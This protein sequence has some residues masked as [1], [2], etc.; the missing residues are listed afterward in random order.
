MMSSLNQAAQS[1][2]NIEDL[3]KTYSRQKPRVSRVEQLQD[4]AAITFRPGGFADSFSGGLIQ[5]AGHSVMFTLNYEID[6]A[7]G[8]A[9][10]PVRGLSGRVLRNGCV[11]RSPQEVCLSMNFA[12]QPRQ[13]GRGPVI[14]PYRNPSLLETALRMD[15]RCQFIV[16]KGRSL[17]SAVQLPRVLLGFSSNCLP[18]FEVTE[19]LKQRAAANAGIAIND[20]GRMGEVL[21]DRL[22]RDTWEASFMPVD[23]PLN[24]T[25]LTLLDRELCPSQSQFLGAYEDFADLVGVGTSNP[26]RNLD[27]CP[28]PNPARQIWSELGFGSTPDL[29][30]QLPAETLGKLTSLMRST[31]GDRAGE[32]SDEDLC[33][34]LT[35][36]DTPLLAWSKLLPAIRSRL[37]RWADAGATDDDLRLAVIEPSQ[38]L[39]VRYA[40][41]VQVVAR[42]AISSF[43]DPR[44]RRTNEQ[45]RVSS[46]TNNCEPLLSTAT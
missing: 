40:S 32:F 30:Q 45:A 3:M 7:H 15:H 44:W 36:L 46:V 5:R 17:F 29:E 13:G 42:E 14:D 35:M 25:G 6:A 22:L 4:V 33:D 28:I 31:L 12:Y 11:R 18:H 21:C 19:A 38:P 9:S 2:W 16:S 41:R 34:G 10:V 1:Q 20:I 8:R 23:H 43:I 26:A 39:W 27:V 24:P 37:P